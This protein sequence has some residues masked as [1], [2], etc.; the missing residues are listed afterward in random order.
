MTFQP[1]QSAPLN[2][3]LNYKSIK[4]E[5]ADEFSLL[6]VTLDKNLNWKA[7]VQKI[8]TKLSRF[9]HSE[10]LKKT[11]DIPTAL[12]TYYAYAHAWLSYG[13]I[14]WGNSTEASDLLIQQK[15]LVRIIANI[16]TTDSCKPYFQKFKILTLP[17]LYILESCK[18]VRKNPELYTKKQDVLGKPSRYNNNLV[19]PLS[20]IKLCSSGTLPMSIKIYNKLPNY[21]K[22]E[23]NYRVFIKKL[24][25]MLNQKCYYTVNEYLEDSEF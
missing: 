22:E 19:I 24:K 1:C 15:K 3:N 12:V 16:V 2:I 20:R 6:G 18:F 5:Q 9:A 11:T 21:M 4:I 13:V 14:L 25:N 23:K 7:H 17:S 10:K 8:Y